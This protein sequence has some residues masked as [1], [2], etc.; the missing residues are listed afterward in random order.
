MLTSGM[1][2]LAFGLSRERALRCSRRSEHPSSWPRPA[3]YGEDRRGGA[4]LI[5]SRS[6]FIQAAIL[7]KR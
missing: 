2:P 5:R 4:A 1:V 3:C 6:A 7:V